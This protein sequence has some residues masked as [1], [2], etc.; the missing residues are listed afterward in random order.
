MQRFVLRPPGK[1][2]HKRRQQAPQGLVVAADHRYPVA[3]AVVDLHHGSR[4]RAQD[5]QDP[6]AIGLL[7]GGGTQ[8]VPQTG[9]GPA[10]STQVLA[11]WS[12]TQSFTNHQFGEGGAVATILLLVC[13][14]LVVPY[15][16]W[17]MK[18]TEK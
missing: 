1:L 11:L 16:T 2:L 9:G 8:S 18:D 14:V 7:P 12:Y 17:S 15:L 4:G 6:A 10:Q 13:L 5:I 3:V